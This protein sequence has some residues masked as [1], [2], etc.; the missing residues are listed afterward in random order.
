MKN[1]FIYTLLSLFLIQT[2]FAQKSDPVLFTVENN[3]IHLSEFKYIYSKT[4]GD[5]ADF[6]KKSLEEYLD[7]YTKFK[8]KVQ[9]GKDLKLDTLDS[10]KKELEGYRQQLA[11]SYLIDKEVTDK[12]VEEAY[13]RTKKDVS[14][15]HIFFSCEKEAPARDT[16]AVYSKAMDA[17][18]R[19]DSGSITFENLA[20]EV[21]DDKSAKENGGLLGYLTAM[22]PNGF[23]NLENG[24]YSLG[25]GQVSAPIRTDLGYHVIKVNDIRDARGEVE[26]AH[27]LVRKNENQTYEQGKIKIDSIYGLLQKGSNFEESAKIFSEDKTTGSKG[28]YVGVFGIN[29]YEKAFEDAAFGLTKDGEYTKPFQSSA[30][31]HILKRISKKDIPAYDIAKRRLKPLVQKD[32]RH[33]LSKQALIA[34]IKKDNKFEETPSAVSDFAKTLNNEDFLSH[35]WKSPE[36]RNNTT[37]FKLAGKNYTVADVADYMEKAGRRRLTMNKE[38]PMEEATKSLYKD[39]VDETCVKYEESMLETRYPEFKALM[40]EYEEGILLFE[41]TKNI[42]WDKA[43]ADSVGLQQY[44]DG[45]K[46]AYKWDDRAVVKQYTIK[47]ASKV[48]VKE[49]QDFCKKN[50]SDKVLEK[51]NEKDK[52]ILLAV[53]DKTFEKGRNKLVDNTSWKEGEMSQIETDPRSKSV[54][55]YM[56]EK[57]I[58]SSLKNLSEARGYVVADYQD[59]LEKKWVEELQSKYKVKVNKEVLESLIKK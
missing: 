31:W 1:K 43:S 40:R 54:V 58:P 57:V 19:L 45:H 53:Q 34:K 23:Y 4:N 9:K 49:V 13:Q 55:F 16:L 56:I 46:N 7:L 27:I 29:K 48:R 24:I 51:F 59:F 39:M 22:L 8:L 15:S 12:L 17:K 11:G 5:K 35:K 6:S 52:E 10:Y 36:A 42:V 26:V 47:D 20:K 14:I 18:R 2:I 50:T 38:I 37:A 32:G 28:G 3:P 41:A 33:E 44:Y 30:G 25:K 21:S